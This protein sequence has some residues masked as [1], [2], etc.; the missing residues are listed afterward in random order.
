[1]KED[2][3]WVVRSKGEG[4]SQNYNQFME[5]WKES[6]TFC[7]TELCNK[8]QN[9]MR[10]WETPNMRKSNNLSHS[11]YINI[12]NILVYTS[13]SIFL[14]SSRFLSSTILKNKS[15]DFICSSVNLQLLRYNVS[16][17]A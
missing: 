9:Y 4:K 3:H 17:I 5:V 2:K 13:S 1:M 6:T 16:N 7:G 14:R 10:Y 11:N 8:N 12:C 15:T